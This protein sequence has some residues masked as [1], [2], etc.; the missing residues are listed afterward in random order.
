M[1]KVT[2]TYEF[3]ENDVRQGLV[4]RFKELYG[5]DVDPSMF[6]FDIVDSSSDYGDHGMGYDF[7]PARIR[8]VTLEV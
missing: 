3:D 2:T 1:A 6:K 7:T 8:K 4:W 5:T